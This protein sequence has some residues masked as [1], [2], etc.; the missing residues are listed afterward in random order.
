[1]VRFGRM[2]E[3]PY[4]AKD[5]QNNYLFKRGLSKGESKLRKYSKMAKFIED[6]IKKEK[7]ALDVIVGYMKVHNF[8]DKEDFTSIT[9][10]LPFITPLD[11]AL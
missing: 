9:T 3:K 2:I 6:K 11:M 7:W 5:A 8:F 10:P 4:N 1:M